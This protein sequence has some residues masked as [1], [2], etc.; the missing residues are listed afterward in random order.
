MLKKRL[1]GICLLTFLLLMAASCKESGRADSSESVS[2]DEGITD[3]SVSQNSV[4]ESN[5]FT[6]PGISAAASDSTAAA[7]QS[8]NDGHQEKQSREEII[9][10]AKKYV[11]LQ[12]ESGEVIY[13]PSKNGGYRYGP[14]ILL[15]GDKVDVWFSSPGDPEQWDWIR[16]RHSDDGGKTWTNDKIVLRP[17]PCSDDSFSV[18]DPC[19]IK[20]NGYFYIGYTSTQ[21]FRGT[22]NSLYIARSTNPDGPFEKWDGSGWGGKPKAVV[23][24]TGNP[25]NFGCGEPGFVLNNGK[26]FVYY[27]WNDTMQGTKVAIADGN[28]ENWPGAL[29]EQGTA[30]QKVSSKEDSADIKYIEEYQKF[31]SISVQDRFSDNSAILIRQ[32]D[33]GIHFEEAAVMKTNIAK[34]AHNAGISSR[35]DGHISIKDHN[36]ICYAFGSQSSWGAWSTIMNPISFHLSETPDH[37]ENTGNTFYNNNVATYSGTETVTG[38]YCNLTEYRLTTSMNAPRIGIYALTNHD[39]AMD[40]TAKSGITYTG[41]NSSVIKIEN[42]KIIPLADGQTEAILNY[43][44]FSEKIYITVGDYWY[45]TVSSCENNTNWNPLFL[46]DNSPLTIFSSIGGNVPTWVQVQRKTAQAISGVAITPR[47]GGI[48]FPSDF[49]LQYSSDGVNWIDIAGQSYQNYKK[50]SNNSTIRFTFSSPVNTRF[51]RL[52]STNQDSENGGYLQLGGFIP[53]GKV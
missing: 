38:I 45:P 26:I 28:N 8:T 42:H 35:A 3:G 47:S 49:V 39:S 36:F 33:D 18:C 53:F 27:T 31:I 29:A 48:G 23:Q 7:S 5:P 17:T 1:A 11:N 30:F 50:P 21:D 34:K 32:S 22:D 52:Y 19:V 43:K 37:G 13:M 9:V 41:Y 16:Y 14:S 6:N 12:A 20:W 44:G 51:L 2:P 40:I 46:T 24:F 10:K 15:D 4:E 25:N